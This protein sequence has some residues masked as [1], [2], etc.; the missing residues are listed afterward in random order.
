MV[1]E[2]V[3][4]VSVGLDGFH[5]W[6]CPVRAA[7]N[8]L[9]PWRAQGRS[10]ISVLTCAYAPASSA[11]KLEQ[12]PQKAAA[13]KATALRSDLKGDARIAGREAAAL[14]LAAFK[15]RRWENP[16]CRRL[17]SVLTCAYASGAARPGLQLTPLTP[18]A[19][20]ATGFG[21]QKSCALPP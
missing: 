6:A 2:V 18:F 21:W 16:Q 14:G 19:K 17:T 4:E 15:A 10:Q 13:L 11:P 5:A 8:R 3:S 9:A 12:K 7:Y 20:D 1:P